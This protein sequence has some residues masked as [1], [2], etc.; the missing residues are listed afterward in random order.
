MIE[1][2]CAILEKK[3]SAIWPITQFLKAYLWT[4]GKIKHVAE[5]TEVN[6]LSA[7]DIIVQ[8]NTNETWAKHILS[9]VA[10]QVL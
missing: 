3:S 7:V 8:M 10:L 2:V 6:D 5:A 9:N 4:A 1:N